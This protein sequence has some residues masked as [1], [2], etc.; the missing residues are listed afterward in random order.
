MFISGRFVKN[1]SES[2][3]NL[4]IISMK[5][6]PSILTIQYT[7]D[8]EK[9]F[10]LSMNMDHIPAEDI[11]MIMEIMENAKFEK[12]FITNDESEYGEPDDVK[13]KG[14]E[15]ASHMGDCINDASN[16]SDVES[17]QNSSVNPEDDGSE[18]IKEVSTSN[19]KSKDIEEEPE[20]K[21]SRYRMNADK[22]A[23]IQEV[24]ALT[25]GSMD[26]LIKSFIDKFEIQ[27]DDKELVSASIRAAAQSQDKK[28]WTTLLESQDSPEIRKRLNSYT[29]RYN[30]YY[31]NVIKKLLMNYKPKNTE[32]KLRLFIADTFKPAEML[33]DAQM[34]FL[35]TLFLDEMYGTMSQAEFMKYIVKNSKYEGV[36]KETDSINF[37]LINLGTELGK[38]CQDAWGTLSLDQITKYLRKEVRSDIV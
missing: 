28:D 14:K 26:S 36:R 22:E 9:G 33:N 13:E 38:I 34:S 6:L 18:T 4:L 15:Y 20:Q 1:E 37:S 5:N 19:S 21:K 10:V 12:Y 35:T 3:R 2:A 31:G 25:D 17:E 24:I 7:T 32:R 11:S 16:M 29:E 23:I 8:L 30:M 27:A